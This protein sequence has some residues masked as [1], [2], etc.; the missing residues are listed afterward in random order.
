MQE[1]KISFP[2]SLVVLNCLFAKKM[3]IHCIFLYD[4]DNFCFLVFC[5]TVWVDGLVVNGLRLFS[6]L[7]KVSVEV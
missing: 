5:D 6:T 4:T 2:G 7:T 1:G 3:A